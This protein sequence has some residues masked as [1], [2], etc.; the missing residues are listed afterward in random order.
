M[1]TTNESQLNIKFLI[2]AGIMKECILWPGGKNGEMTF[3]WKNGEHIISLKELLL[4]VH[5]GA[6]TWISFLI[7]HTQCQSNHCTLVFFHLKHC[8]ALTS[9]LHSQS[10]F[11]LF[12][13][14]YLWSVFEV[15]ELLARSCSKSKSISDS[16]WCR[17]RHITPLVEPLLCTDSWCNAPPRMRKERK[18]CHV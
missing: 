9:S 3:M 13:T 11:S 5:L 14:S 8:W 10:F 2:P 4:P 6:A 18:K 1:K 17:C 12:C 7:S 16:G 15:R